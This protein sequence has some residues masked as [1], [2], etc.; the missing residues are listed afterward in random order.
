MMSSTS[1]RTG[2][3]VYHFLTALTTYDLACEH[4]GHLSYLTHWF[5]VCSLKVETM[6]VIFTFKIETATGS[7]IQ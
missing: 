5:A 4:F 6:T 2:N 3:A 7:C 1:K